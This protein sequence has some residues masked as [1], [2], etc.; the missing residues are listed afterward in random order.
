[1]EINK[2]IQL[3]GISI[4]FF[5]LSA[6]A[7][8]QESSEEPLD[9]IF[10]LGGRTMPVNVINVGRTDVLY[11]KPD[12]NTIFSIERKQIQKIVYKTGGVDV[13]NKPILEMIGEDEWESVWVTEKEKDVEGLYKYGTV[14]GSSPSSSRS[15]KAAKKNAII[16]MQ[17]KAVNMGGN[18][19]LITKAEM[20]GGYGEIPGYD[21]EAKVYG[22]N[23]PPEEEEN[24]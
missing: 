23:P 7:S 8:G 18:V 1:M 10:R 6:V 16:I 17:K 19:I 2:L 14:K 9:T 3:L 12:D 20:K 11:K 5:A 21:M 13:F 24:E 4:I 22:Y 15:K